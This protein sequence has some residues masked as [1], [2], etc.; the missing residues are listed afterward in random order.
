ML[1]LWGRV[2]G[3]TR[4]AGWRCAGANTGSSE[5]KGGSGGGVDW[6]PNIT[7]E[8]KSNDAHLLAKMRIQRMSEYH[9]FPDAAIENRLRVQVIPREMTCYLSRPPKIRLASSKVSFE[10]MSNHKPGTVQ[11]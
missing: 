11:V 7:T 5:G 3:I 9:C 1:F 10:P 4:R 6:A 8:E 2:T